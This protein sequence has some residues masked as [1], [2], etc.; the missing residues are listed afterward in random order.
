VKALERSV[1]ATESALP[2]LFLNVT[3]DEVE[4]SV[5]FSVSAKEPFKVT[6]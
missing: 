1:F 5:I 3:V 2:A 4:E 6:L